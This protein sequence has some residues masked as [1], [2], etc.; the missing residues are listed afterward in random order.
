MDDQKEEEEQKWHSESDDD[1]VDRESTA[2]TKQNSS[3]TVISCVC[4]SP[5]QV[6]SSSFGC[7]IQSCD[8]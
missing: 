7:V 5:G 4:A 2:E 6:S 3:H 1:A 8:S